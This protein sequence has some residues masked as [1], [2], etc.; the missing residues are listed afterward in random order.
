M[1]LGSTTASTLTLGASRP[2]LKLQQIG[3]TEDDSQSLALQSMVNLYLT[4]LNN[5]RE[6]QTGRKE[7][8]LENFLIVTCQSFAE[9]EDYFSPEE[10]DDVLNDGKQTYLQLFVDYLGKSVKPLD[11]NLEERS[12]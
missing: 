12:S 1:R 4:N 7:S 6:L 10:F 9:Y 11:Q 3:P 2:L 8:S 5:E